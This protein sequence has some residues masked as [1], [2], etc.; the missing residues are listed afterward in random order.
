MWWMATCPQNFLALISLMFFVV[1]VV[2]VVG[3]CCLFVF[4][5]DNALYGDLSDISSTDT[6]KWS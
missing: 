4:F 6:A 1:V 5:L 3:L 2:V